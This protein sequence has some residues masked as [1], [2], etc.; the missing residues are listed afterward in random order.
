METGALIR[1]HSIDVAL[2]CCLL[3]ITFFIANPSYSEQGSQSQDNWYAY[4]EFGWA[5]GTDYF[6]A[7]TL[8]DPAGSQPPGNGKSCTKATL[9]YPSG[10]VITA[11]GS[12]DPNSGANVTFM[13]QPGHFNGTSRHWIGT[14]TCGADDSETAKISLDHDATQVAIDYFYANPT[15]V[16]PSGTSQLSWSTRNGTSI[17]INGTTVLAAG[18]MVVNPSTSTS[19][20]L[21]V[22][23]S[24][25]STQTRVTVRKN[26]PLTPQYYKYAVRHEKGVSPFFPFAQVDQESVNS[27][28]G[29]LNFS[30]PLLSRPGRSGMGLNIKLAY[31]SKI[32]DFFVQNNTLFATIPEYDSWVGL[33]WTLTAGRII[34]DSANGFYYLTTSDGANHTLTSYGGAWRS[35]DSSYMVYDPANKKLTSK[36]GTSIYFNY[37]DPVRPYMRYA[38]RLQDMNGNYVDIAYAGTGGKISNIQDTLG[39][40]YTFQLDYYNS[41]LQY[42][43]YKN[44]N[45]TTQTISFSYDFAMPDFGTQA[46]MDPLVGQQKRLTQIAYYSFNHDFTYNSSGQIESIN[47]PTTGYSRYF[48]TKYTVF[49]RVLGRTVPDFYVTSHDTGSATP[50]WTWSNNPSSQVA[51]SMV[52]ITIPSRS[53]VKHFMEKSSLGWADGFA[54][55]GTYADT[56]LSEVSSQDWAQDDEQLTTIKNPRILWAKKGKQ[57]VTSPYTEKLV[58]KEFS[59]APTNDYSGNIKEVREYAFDQVTLRRKTVL[60]YLHETNGTYANLNILD[61]VTSTLVYNGSNNLISKATTAYDAYSPLYSA[62]NAIRHDAAFGTTYLTRGLPTSVTRWYDIAQNLSIT[63]STKYDE[64]GNVRE[65][66]DPNARTTLTSYWLSSADNAYAF[67]LRVQNAKGHVGFAT[68]SYYSGA[69]LTSTDTNGIVTTSTYDTLDRV[70]QTTRSDGAKSTVDYVASDY[71]PP[72]ALTRKYLTASTYIEQRSNLDNFGRLKQVIAP[73]NITQDQTFSAAGTVI[74]SSLPYIAGQT[75][76]STTYSDAAVATQTTNFPDGQSIQYF[77]DPNT[78]RVQR[79]D[80]R[81]RKSSYQE[82]GKIEYVLEQDPVNGELNLRTDYGYDALGRLTS[83]VQG[84]QTRSF[85]YD[86]IGRLKTETYPETGSTTYEY[87]ANSNLTVKTDSRGIITNVAYDELNRPT[88]K[89]YS[90]G[91]P[92]VSYYYDAQPTDSPITIVY[93][94]GRL[95][96]VMTTTSGV[97]VKNFYSYCSCSSVIQESMTVFDGS[98]TKTYTTSYTHNLA[99]QLT[100]VAYPNGKILTYTRNSLGRETKV[101]STWNGHAFDYV[102]GATYGGPQGAITEILYPLTGYYGLNGKTEFTYSPTNLHLTHMAHKYL[103]EPR[104]DYNFSYTDSL[105]RPTSRIQDATNPQY[106][107]QSEHYQYDYLDRVT[108]YW[109]SNQRTDPPSRKLEFSYDRYGNITNVI[110]NQGSS[111]A[112]TVDSATNRLSSRVRTGG[113]SSYSY[114]AAGNAISYGTFDAENRLTS[115]NGTAYLYDGNGRRFRV[116]GTSTKNYIYS[117]SGQ[118]LEEDNVTAG[119]TDLNI[120]FNGQKV[121]IQGQQVD[122]FKLLLNDY[123]G[124]VR[125][126]L[127]IGL[128]WS[129]LGTQYGIVSTERYSYDPWGQSYDPWGQV[130]TPPYYF[131]HQD[132]ER[133]GGLDYFGARYYDGG[134]ISTGSGTRW[135]SPDPVTSNAYDPQ[136][137]NKYAYVRNDPVNSM[138]PDGRQVVIMDP[139]VYLYYLSIGWKGPEIEHLFGS[140][141]GFDLNPI[142]AY[143]FWTGEDFYYLPGF[144]YFAFG[145]WY[146]GGGSGGASSAVQLRQETQKAINDAWNTI[147]NKDGEINKD[148]DCYKFLSWVTSMA[149]LKDVTP[150]SILS[151]LTP[152]N[153]KDNATGAHTGAAWKDPGEPISLKDEV[154]NSAY[155]SYLYATLIHEALHFFIPTNDQLSKFM[156]QADDYG[157]EHSG[158]GANNWGFGSLSSYGDERTGFVMRHCNLTEIPGG[159]PIGT[160]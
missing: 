6:N 62:S 87:D 108:A 116:Q 55:K 146:G 68:Y 46:T 44:T 76:Y 11:T 121:A 111:F 50:T 43:S 131:R 72:Y 71:A 20:V 117:F 88:L 1:K 48:Y 40:T 82:D 7:Y 80:G 52:Q 23:N 79:N 31:N 51:P 5:S 29:N 39:N 25:T 64:C 100:S 26:E 127:A 74:A 120:Y 37:Q 61:K 89:S 96:R 75:P 148:G 47:Y 22:S 90:D 141:P 109:M 106:P 8:V 123:K 69:S 138:D 110:V 122:Q 63:A 129:Y 133:D 135:I 118:L 115:R 156:K 10:Q 30:I 143:S 70:T 42:I 98:T 9:T 149:G 17:N 41:V 2:L 21:T 102:Y 154:G 151:M 84:V 4:A 86:D 45:N 159:R 158:R 53:T 157:M 103:M 77:N 95:T 28:N 57:Q 73:G 139:S 136:S 150:E 153:I 56:S 113:Q 160:R 132:K 114:D 119:T 130:V 91:T 12:G 99:D 144:V 35:M 78:S 27:A 60:S 137:L 147:K 83:I 140:L 107:D 81:Q 128:T 16:Q 155:T 3:C 49:D 33:G 15:S 105:G 142:W 145:G 24:Q 59:Y 58:K 66:T 67:P 13:T 94:T 92:S 65:V 104:Y 93:P 97:T 19:Y 125:V 14:L 85:A 18:S 124:S 152:N 134:N 36:N 34:D 54:T 112:F 38:T 126:S 32:W 101:S